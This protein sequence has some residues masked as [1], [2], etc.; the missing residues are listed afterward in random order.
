MPVVGQRATAAANASCTASSA[1]SMSPVVRM[2]VAT[3]RPYCSRKT[4]SMSAD[5]G[6]GIGL[7]ASGPAV[8]LGDERPDLDRQGGGAGDLASPVERLVE[9]RR[10]N[11]REPGEV[12]LPLREGAVGQQDLVVLQPQHAGGARGVQTV[13]ED[14]G[15]G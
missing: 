7:P 10:P 9:V 8:G 14:P 3:A 2:S 4:C 11:D 15:S 13:R 12:L 1:R 5:V 6:C